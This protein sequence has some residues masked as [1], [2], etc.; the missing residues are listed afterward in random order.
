MTDGA[1]EATAATDQQQQFKS[2]GKLI[3]YLN[4]SLGEGSYGKV[5]QGLFENKVKVAVKR[6]DKS[7][8][9]FDEQDI[10]IKVDTH[11]NIVRYY[12]TEIARYDE[13]EYA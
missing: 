12:C 6:I 4:E 8:V 1:M 13:I 10:L 5:F 11:E 9:Q 7:K 2:I 3:V